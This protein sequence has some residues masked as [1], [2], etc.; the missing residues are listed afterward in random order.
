MSMGDIMGDVSQRRGKVWRD[1]G[2]EGH[3]QVINAEIPLSKFT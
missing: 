3:F 2:N 1:G